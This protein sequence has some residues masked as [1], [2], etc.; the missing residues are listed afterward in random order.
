[1]TM[2]GGPAAACR[3]TTAAAA[4]SATAESEPLISPQSISSELPEEAGSSF[5]HILIQTFIV[6]ERGGE[7]ERRKSAR[8]DRFD[9]R[10]KTKFLS[11]IN[12]SLSL[13]SLF[14]SLTR[15]LCNKN[16]SPFSFHS[17]SSLTLSSFRHL[18]SSVIIILDW[19]EFCFKSSVPFPFLSLRTMGNKRKENVSDSI[20]STVLSHSHL[21]VYLNLSFS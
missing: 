17:F 13:S 11:E 18:F 21:C 1:M 5:F 14:H 6:A 16:S 4:T 12:L 10:I 19:I 2:R 3:L 7:G 15:A 9:N 20:V 8:I